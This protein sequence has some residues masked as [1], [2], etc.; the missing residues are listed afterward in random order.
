MH[1]F[2]VP[3]I[4][5]AHCKNSIETALA[6]VPQA[7]PVAVDIPGKQVTTGGQAPVQAVLAALAEI[8][9]PAQVVDGS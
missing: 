7:G 9:F 3:D 4:S 5:C 1:R 6:A 2:S 8:G